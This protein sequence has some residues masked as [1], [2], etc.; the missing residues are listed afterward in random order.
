MRFAVVQVLREAR[1]H[2]SIL[3]NVDQAARRIMVVAE[4]RA[5]RLAYRLALL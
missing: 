4:K 1:R 2:F 5:D 3:E